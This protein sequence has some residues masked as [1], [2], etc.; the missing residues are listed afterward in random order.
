[1]ALQA[2]IDATLGRQGSWL[3][4]ALLA[5]AALIGPG[6][7]FF[8]RGLPALRRGAPDMNSL[9][10][11]GAG[12]AW[13]F[14]I[15]ALAAPRL[16]PPGTAHVYFEAAVVVAALILA[17][18]WL[19]AR[20]RGRASHAI[21]RLV[22]LQ[23]RTARVRRGGAL[24]EVPAEDVVQGDELDIRPGERLPVDGEVLA[25]ESRVDESL[26]TGEPAPVLKRP[27][28][29]VIGG[30][31]NGAGALTLRATAVGADALLAQIIRMVEDAQSAKLPIQALVDRATLWFVPAVM[32]AAALTFAAW[33]IFGPAPALPYALANAVAVLIIACPCAMGLATPV[34]IM[35]GAGRGAELG[36]LFRKGE[37]LQALQAARVVAFDKTGTLTDGA[38]RL[39]A[40]LTA[41]DEDRPALLQA[42][43]TLEARSE[44]PLAHAIVAAAEVDAGSGPLDADP[45]ASPRDLRPD[46]SPPATGS[47]ASSPAIRSGAFSPATGS[48]VFSPGAED[49]E[50]VPG[51]GLRG[52]VAGGR[53]EIGADRFMARLG[54]DASAF[55]P[56]AERLAADGATPVYAARDGRVVA[57]LA[58]SDPIRPAA[59]PTVA[60]LHALGLK[61]A[62]ITG[63]DRRAARAV[64]A[65]LGIEEVTA[66]VMPG[67]KVEAL[68]TL[69]AAHGPVAFV[70][71]GLNDA[72]A[73]AEAEAGLALATGT[74]VAIEAADAVL[75]SGA[76]SGV[77]TAFALS[78]AV[79]R[80]IRQ[81]L[82]W[83]FAY[84][85][86]L[87]PV[88][89]GLLW[90]AFGI[91]LS[92]MLA[93][94]AMSLSSVSVLANALRLRRVSPGAPV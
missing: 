2:L 23:A 28:D 17:G 12:A 52:R 48:G 19:E 25:G 35:V 73:L 7:P 14:S 11:V 43:A 54:R 72:P 6:R 94:A 88:A 22:G 24:Q 3:I 92:P 58:I 13:L 89:A 77:P 60:A 32:A 9:V 29:A 18:R 66:E 74:D 53:Y 45:N 42:L 87:I 82:F 8:D 10:A 93:A 61:T 31:I 57:L 37:A 83:A 5:T 69:R 71:D 46:A 51:L 76:L 20:A 67:G 55:A 34:S 27:G 40:F 86:A 36:V 78:R 80:N 91:L 44:H 56:Q 81:N 49:V 38:P 62:L 15:V 47:G 16:L 68:K 63:D 75:V 79:I 50:S 26:V 4:Q 90:P 41:A 84:N 33:L 65:R 1:P 39:T 85:A 30:T 64:A 70:G 21:R 59:A